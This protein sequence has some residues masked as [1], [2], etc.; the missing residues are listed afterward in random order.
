M[1]SSF[2]NSGKLSIGWMIAIGLVALSFITVGVFGL[3][4]LGT[5]N[6]QVGYANLIEAKTEANKTDLSNL[7]SKFSEVAQV[8]DEQMA[9]LSDLFTRYAE[10][11]TSDN[12]GAVMNW[13][14]ETVPNVDQSTY[15]NL[16]NIIVATRDSW[17]ERQKELYEVVLGAQ[18]AAR[19][20]WWILSGS[21]TPRSTGCPVAPC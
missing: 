7:K 19:R 11:R 17:T 15:R 1:R 16:Q 2:S 14:Q 8:T 5:Y 3:W 18:K 21:T 6:T 9:Q 10:A 20:S 12:A 4:A 13:V